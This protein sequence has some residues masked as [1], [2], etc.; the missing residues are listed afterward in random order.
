MRLTDVTEWLTISGSPYEDGT[1]VIT[2]YIGSKPSG[3]FTTD[4]DPWPAALEAW[5]TAAWTAALTINV[6]YSQAGS[7][8][9]WPEPPTPRVLY[10]LFSVSR[11]EFVPGE[12]YPIAKE[13][14][15]GQTFT[16]HDYRGRSM[17][18]LEVE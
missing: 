18:D 14:G 10:T 1:H 15:R 13:V 9:L 16:I 4:R 3:T 6:H 17:V 7:L 5:P 12:E 8:L 11:V 2:T